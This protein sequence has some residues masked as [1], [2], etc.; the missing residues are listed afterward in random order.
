MRH[1]KSEVMSR[2]STETTLYLS[3]FW[4][5]AN[6]DYFSTLAVY[7]QEYSCCYII[8]FFCSFMFG[9]GGSE[10]LA[11]WKFINWRNS[12]HNWTENSI[13]W[14]KFYE[15]FFDSNIKIV[16]S[17]FFFKE[18]TWTSEFF[19]CSFICWDV[20]ISYLSWLR[21]NNHLTFWVLTVNTDFYH[22]GY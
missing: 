20:S 2:F 21:K 8:W 7:I 13:L 3:Q 15:S 5:Y 4:K 17:E 16:L 10:L 6:V 19:Q 22:G 14:P 18:P 9:R 12:W 1:F 11:A